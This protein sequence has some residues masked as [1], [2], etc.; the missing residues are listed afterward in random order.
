MG[1]NSLSQVSDLVINIA[2]K[3]KMY[4]K[5]GQFSSRTS[6]LMILDFL[7][8]GIFEKDYDSNIEYISKINKKIVK[9]NPKFS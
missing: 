9:K 1:N 3:E 2:T 5:I 6:I 8:A 4:S 7:Y